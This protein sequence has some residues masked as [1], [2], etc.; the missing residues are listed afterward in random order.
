[1]RSFTLN[2]IRLTLY[3]LSLMHINLS[4]RG[5]KVLS[6]F[7]KFGIVGVSNTAVSYFIYVLSLL[8]LKH[9]SLLS[10]IDYLIA[11]L[12]SFVLSVLWSFYW[13]SKYVFR[14]TRMGSV[15][16]SLI[17]TYASYA[18]SGLFLSGILLWVLVDVLLVS[19][20]IAPVIVLIITVPTN[21]V[22]NKFWAFR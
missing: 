18:F 7:I 15:W 19:D 21:F 5:Q 17:K 10:S 4:D 13:N 11:L 1:M 16:G 2:L 9:F 8:L 3:I 22:L 20:F 6:E 12:L 14:D